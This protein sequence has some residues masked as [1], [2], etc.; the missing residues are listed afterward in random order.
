MA[1]L[2]KLPFTSMKKGVRVWVYTEEEGWKGGGQGAIIFPSNLN[3]YSKKAKDLI[4]Y[5]ILYLLF[6]HEVSNFTSAD[7]FCV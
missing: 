3:N 2:P 5:L 7:Q 1:A 4:S 6:S